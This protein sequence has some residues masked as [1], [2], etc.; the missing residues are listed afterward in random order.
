MIKIGIVGGG[1]VGIATQKF[2][3]PLNL[4]S[5]YDTDEKKCI[6]PGTT[7]Q[8]VASSDLI[9]VC[10][11]SPSNEDGSA[12]I[13]T[14]EKVVAQLKTA[15]ATKAIIVRSTVPVGT[16]DALGV[17]H[18]PEFLTEKNWRQ[19]FVETAQWILG[20]P[21]HDDH[22]RVHSLFTSLVINA[23][24]F[25][26]I[27]SPQIVFCSNVEAEMVKHYRNTLLSVKVA[28]CNEL[29][30]F[31]HLKGIEYNRVRQIATADKRIGDSHTQVPGPDGLKG[32]G[33]K[34]FPKD[35]KSLLYEMRK[36]GMKAPILA[37]ALQRNR[38]EDRTAFGGDARR[39]SS[40]NQKLL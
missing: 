39:A 12:D 32:F 5:I 15:N 2:Q 13:R 22:S 40:E 31:C 36:V 4:V 25:Y 16:C 29:A 33:G 37:G 7:F 21:P 34:C 8:D 3:T 14:V 30:Q 19:D 6:P 18:L 17:Y 23:F 20:S 1:V 35:S 26:A 10:V 28:Y 24:E 11:P 9:F 38:E 27:Q